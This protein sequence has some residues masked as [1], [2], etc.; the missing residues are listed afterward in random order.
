MFVSLV[1]DK[2]CFVLLLYSL[3]LLFLYFV[4]IPC[5]F[6]ENYSSPQIRRTHLPKLGTPVRLI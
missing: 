3:Y 2:H 5:A 1:R 4:T 6:C